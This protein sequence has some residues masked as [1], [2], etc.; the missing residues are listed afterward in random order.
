[1]ADLFDLPRLYAEHPYVIWLALGALL[2]AIEVGTGSGW[3]LWPVAAA[4]VVALRAPLGIEASFAAELAVFAG[5]TI[6]S[7][8]AAK[9]F[10]P[11]RRHDQPDIN[12][13]ITQLIGHHGE[14]VGQFVD[15]RGRVLVDGA[16]WAAEA[17]DGT[18]PKPGDRIEVI[19][20]AGGA[21]LEVRPV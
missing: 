7:T 18:T 16:E 14:A 11:K 1:M 4:V 12:D 3:L 8:L 15:G 10:L 19:R 17:I 21:R 9:R 13:R 6:V 20:V 5:L 2:L